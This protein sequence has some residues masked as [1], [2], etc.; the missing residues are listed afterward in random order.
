MVIRAA[1]GRR[2]GAVPAEP[3]GPCLDAGAAPECSRRG[4]AGQHAARQDPTARPA[5]HGSAHPAER[6]GRRRH[7]MALT[8]VLTRRPRLLVTEESASA[9]TTAATRLVLS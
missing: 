7:P 4:D 5:S 8:P 3:G 9:L 1:D 2:S 6:S